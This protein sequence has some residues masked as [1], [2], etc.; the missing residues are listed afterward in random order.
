MRQLTV[1]IPTYNEAENLPSLIDNLVATSISNLKLIIVDDGSPDG[2]GQLAEELAIRLPGRLSVVHRPG[3]MGLGSAYIRG[4]HVA[5][6]EGAEA[7]GQMDADF[8]HSPSYVPEFLAQLEHWDAVFGSRYVDGGRVDERWSV[9]RV[10]LS[11]FGNTYA[12]VILR[13]QVQDSTGGFRF[14]RAETL[15]G[16]P[17]ERIRSEGYVFQVEMAYLAQRMGFR[18]SEQPIY[19][20]DRRIGQSKMSLRIQLEAAIRVWLLPYVYRGLQPTRA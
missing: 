15:R 20:E 16:L 6:S 10:I 12:R 14:W 8:S 19:F 4:F 1:V 2:T 9:G 11:K 7:V 13:L 18:I 17:L 3:K 5:L